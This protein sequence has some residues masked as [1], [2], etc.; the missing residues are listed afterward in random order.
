MKKEDIPHDDGPLTKLTKEMCYA[1]DESGRYTTELSEGWA[2]KK[3]ALEVAWT[4]VETRIAS[5]RQKVLDGQASPIL[6]FMELKLMDVS[7]LAAYTGHW[8]WTV[9]RHLKP[10]VFHKLSDKTLQRYADLF[11]CTVQDIKTM[12][13]H[14]A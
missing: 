9:K 1:V 5:A 7:I 10:R 6:Y 4:D 12:H 2:V 14:E 8:T 11:E 3:E 13:T